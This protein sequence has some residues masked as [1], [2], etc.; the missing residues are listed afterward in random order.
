MLGLVKTKGKQRYVKGRLPMEH[1]NVSAS[2]TCFLIGTVIDLQKFILS[3]TK[4]ENLIEDS[5]EEKLLSVPL[6]VPTSTADG[7]M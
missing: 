1:P 2:T 4:I 6:V 3:P 5:E 7:T